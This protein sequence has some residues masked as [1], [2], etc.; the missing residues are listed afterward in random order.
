MI[1]SLWRCCLLQTRPV[2]WPLFQG[3]WIC[4]WLILKVVGPFEKKFFYIEISWS[5][6]FNFAYIVPLGKIFWCIKFKYF[7][8]E[9][10]SLVTKP[11]VHAEWILYPSFLYT[12]Y[13]KIL[14]HL[15][16]HL[17]KS[18]CM[19]TWE[20]LAQGLILSKGDSACNTDF[21]MWYTLYLIFK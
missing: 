15:L 4:H 2:S 14:N 21:A 16:Y 20:P 19:S 9:L 12:K 18:T 7:E 10:K 13:G 3:F 5:I 11:Q 17:K 8:L 6:N 1:E